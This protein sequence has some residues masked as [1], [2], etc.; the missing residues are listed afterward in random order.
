MT[1]FP[2]PDPPDDGPV[3][4]PAVVVAAGERIRRFRNDTDA[5]I[6]WN[7]HTLAPHE[8]VEI[9][10]SADSVT[11]AAGL[12]ETTLTARFEQP[13]AAETIEHEQDE[14]V[15]V[16]D[17]APDETVAAPAWYTPPVDAPEPPAA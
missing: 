2:I 4:E 11:L 7:G 16:P 15:A 9:L 10:M 3:D 14:T 13:A 5:S 1:D 17:A 6:Q 8:D 12:T